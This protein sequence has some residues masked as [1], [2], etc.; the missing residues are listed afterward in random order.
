VNDFRRT[1]LVRRCRG[2]KSRGVGRWSGDS[3]AGPISLKHVDLAHAYIWPQGGWPGP[4][5]RASLRQGRFHEKAAWDVGGGPKKTKDTGQGNRAH[6]R[7]VRRRQSS[8]Q[9]SWALP[10][11]GGSGKPRRR[12]KPGLLPF[13]GKQDRSESQRTTSDCRRDHEVDQ[14]HEHLARERLELKAGG[15]Q[16]RA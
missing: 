14:G 1:P 13:Q 2:R 15:C 9:I 6:Q 8:C 16:Q 3:P 11:L 4:R 5:D 10:F 12:M 7:A